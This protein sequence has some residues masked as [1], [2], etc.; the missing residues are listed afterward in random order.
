MTT[1][2]ESPQPVGLISGALDEFADEIYIAGMNVVKR[3]E[4]G[5]VRQIIQ[6]TSQDRLI[7]VIV[8]MLKWMVTGKYTGHL[9]LHMVKGGL[10]RIETEQDTK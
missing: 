3:E 6:L 10:K 5:I 7:P 1:A 8:A 9:K 2:P 4:I